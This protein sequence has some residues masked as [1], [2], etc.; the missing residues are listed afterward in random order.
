MAYPEVASGNRVDVRG[1][2]VCNML[3][4]M[5][6]REILPCFPRQVRRLRRVA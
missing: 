2:C 4:S 5:M 3:V 1:S 6:A